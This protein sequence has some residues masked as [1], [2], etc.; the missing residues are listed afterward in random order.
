MTGTG[1]EHSRGAR[2][3]LAVVGVIGLPV[4]LVLAAVAGIVWIVCALCLHLIVWFWW[5]GRDRRRVLFVY[6]DS[7]NWKE[8]I[9]ENVL[10]RLPRNAVVLNWSER[11]RW[12]VWRLP[13]MLFR[14]FAGR[15]EFN[16][17]ALVFERFDWVRKYRFWQAFREAK[18]GK[19]G[20][21]HAL[22]LALFK[23][24]AE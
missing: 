10:P 13:A 19:P 8:H 6:S 7:P 5:L 22:E 2:W 21:L 20:K 9:E 14:W 15:R 16:P 3:A 23:D 4:W 18:H 1:A 12:G 17:I 24:L 11:K